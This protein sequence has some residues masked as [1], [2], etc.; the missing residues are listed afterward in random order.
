MLRLMKRPNQRGPIVLPTE[1]KPVRLVALRRK[2][3][4]AR[5]RDSDT[6]FDTAWSAM[7]RLL[8]LDALTLT[9]DQALALYDECVPPEAFSA[10]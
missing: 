8:G 9:F 2:V 4:D 10:R 7:R 1:K 5:F 6:T 3:R